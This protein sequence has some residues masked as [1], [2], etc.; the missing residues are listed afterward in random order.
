MMITSYGSLRRGT[1]RRDRWRMIGGVS[2]LLQTLDHELTHPL[3]VLDQQI[4]TSTLPRE[5]NG[6]RCGSFVASPFNHRLN[7]SKYRYTTGVVNSVSAWLTMSPPTMVYPSG[8]RSSDPVRARASGNAPRQRRHG[9][10]HDGAE[11]QQAG[12][13]DGVVRRQVLLALGLDR[14]I[15]HH[16]AVFLTMRSTG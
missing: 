5:A 15:H 6:G 12:L 2:G 4:F 13:A 14:K 7:S 9:R 1:F 16:D 10:H 3:I 8:W 11:S